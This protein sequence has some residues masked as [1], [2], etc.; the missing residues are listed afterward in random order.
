MIDRRSH[1]DAMLADINRLIA[2]AESLTVAKCDDNT[3]QRASKVLTE[4]RE[5]RRR[6]SEVGVRITFYPVMFLCALPTNV[7]VKIAGMI[8]R[9][10]KGT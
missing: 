2:K 10:P 5:Q 1:L 3:L 6:G 9:H 8:R 4:L 7:K